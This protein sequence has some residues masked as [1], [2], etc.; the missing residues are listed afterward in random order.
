MESF[1]LPTSWKGIKTIS[2]AKRLV[3]Y[4]IILTWREAKQMQ[5]TLET[6]D[7]AEIARHMATR[8][9]ERVESRLPEEIL[10]ES[11]LI[12]L[13]TLNSEEVFSAF[14][15]EILL[16][17]NQADAC[18]T[19]TEVALTSDI[20]DA[21]RSD[22]LF[23]MAVAL[24]CEL[25]AAVQLIYSHY[26]DEMPEANA[27]IDHISTYL[28]SVSNSSNPRIRLSLVH[29]F[30]KIEQGKSYKPGFNRI[31]G[32]FGHTVLEHLFMQLFNKK[33]EGVALQYL[34]GNLPYVLEGDNHCQNI[35]HETLKYYMLKKPERFCLF[36][37]T[38]AYTLQTEDSSRLSRE[39]Y[40]KHLGILLKLTSDLNNRELAKEL[41]ATIAS[42]KGEP[43]RETLLQRIQE[44]RS[45]KVY[46]A[47]NLE[48]ILVQERKGITPRKSPDSHYKTGKRGR[49]PSFAK[50]E[51]LKPM[52]Q[53]TFL[54]K[55]E[56]AKA[57]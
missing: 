16:Q 31:M 28:L 57:S 11:L 37:H 2:T 51:E 18:M 1:E 19:L 20:S 8:F 32:R 39:A 12:L 54:G 25:G 4:G 53:V 45:I 21:E 9:A 26:P 29:Y 24:I 27:I 44:D 35:L 43:F 5:R 3:D 40:L 14:L 15:E 33:T 7:I 42:F 6:S 55:K 49:K 13:S 38:F 50:I 34:L 10:M 36:I 56:E 23:S 30:G 52:D 47:Q 48:K 17:P 41:L 22:E 46:I